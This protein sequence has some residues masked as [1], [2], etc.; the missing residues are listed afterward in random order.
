[1]RGHD[2]HLWQ[3][4]EGTECP[5]H[6]LG[7]GGKRLA[8]S[9]FWHSHTFVADLLV[10]IDCHSPRKLECTAVCAAVQELQQR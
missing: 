10:F 6:G 5:V 4:A 3:R 1:M 9:R 8:Q 7:P 2:D